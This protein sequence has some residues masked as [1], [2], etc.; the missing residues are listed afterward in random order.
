MTLRAYG[1]D[2][3]RYSLAFG[4]GL[5]SRGL[6]LGA[7]ALGINLAR[8]ELDRAA[9]LLELFLGRRADGVDLDGELLGHLTD[10]EDLHAV[11][12]ALDEA[13][14]AE[15]RL[16]DRTRLEQQLEV[17][18]IDRRVADLERGVVEAALGGCGG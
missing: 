18:E 5:R 11:P 9:G 14:G 3:R 7:V 12:G 4:A 17:G 8:E 10:A 2:R 15:T 13:L 1:V 6:D 16:V